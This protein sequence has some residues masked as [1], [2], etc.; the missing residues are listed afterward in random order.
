M[1]TLRLIVLLLCADTGK[2]TSTANNAGNKNVRILF[3]LF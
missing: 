1:A 2:A 3:M